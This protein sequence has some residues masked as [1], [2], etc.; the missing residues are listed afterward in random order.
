MGSEADACSDSLAT[1]FEVGAGMAGSHDD[2][3]ASQPLNRG[4]R[5]RELWRQSDEPR[6]R[7]RDHVDVFG[8]GLSQVRQQMGAFVGR[9]EKRPFDVRAQHAG[10]LRFGRGADL[11]G[12]TRSSLHG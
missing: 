10:S 8:G 1:L 4:E 3:G 12:K 7:G 5:A 2:A 11:G 9:I 6:P